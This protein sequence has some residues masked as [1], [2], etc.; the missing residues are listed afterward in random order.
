MLRV[1]FC[2]CFLYVVIFL[3]LLLFC[4][5]VLVGQNDISPIQTNSNL[6]CLCVCYS[7]TFLFPVYV[8]L[9]FFFLFFLLCVC[10]FLL[11]HLERS[12]W[13]ITKSISERHS[14]YV[15]SELGMCV[16]PMEIMKKIRIEEIKSTHWET[17]KERE[18]KEHT[19]TKYQHIDAVSVWYTCKHVLPTWFIR[20]TLIFI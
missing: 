20:T 2:F 11:F 17:E 9:I 3:V 7:R 5:P 16:D 4:S 10:F 19:N 13:Q 18:R 6:F 15:W 12:T 1:Q 8:S 14:P